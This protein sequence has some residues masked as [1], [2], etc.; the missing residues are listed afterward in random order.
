MAMKL[1]LASLGVLFAASIVGYLVVRSRSEAWPPPDM[2][3]LPAGLWLSTLILL[4]SSGTIQFALASIRRDRKTALSAGMSLTLLLGVAFLV[5]QAI[6]WLRLIDAHVTPAAHMFAFTFFMLTGL[7]AAHVIG[8]LIALAIV[9]TKALRRRYADDY[10]P[11]VIYCTMYWHF[12]DAVWL[13]MFVL[14]FVIP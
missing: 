13:I 11:G 12:L 5:T 14:I 4:V 6:N 8:G 2:P 1:F 3:H 10:H 7:H 9:T